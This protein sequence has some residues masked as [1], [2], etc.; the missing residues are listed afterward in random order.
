MN[1]ILPCG[2]QIA[3]VALAR[4]SVL[5]RIEQATNA[6][7]VEARQAYRQAHAVLVLSKINK[8]SMP[9]PC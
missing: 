9:S 8:R 6:M 2:S 5:Y 3:A 1:N 4:I 7:S